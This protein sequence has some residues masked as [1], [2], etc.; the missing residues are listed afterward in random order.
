VS[1]EKKDKLAYPLSSLIPKGNG[2]PVHQWSGIVPPPPYHDGKLDTGVAVVEYGEVYQS[3]KK[4]IQGIHIC[5]E[6]ECVYLDPK[7]ALSLLAW[8][9]Q[10]E[11]ELEQMAKEVGES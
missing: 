5:D 1:E 10:Q 2:G 8:L 7:Q 4:T 9:R 11:N 3:R 6:D